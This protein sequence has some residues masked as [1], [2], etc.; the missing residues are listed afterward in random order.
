MRGRP[1]NKSLGSTDNVM[2]DHQLETYKSLISIANEGF[3][4]SA[5]INGGAAVAIL[6]YLGNVAGKNVPVPNM[7]CAMAFF[8][9]GIFLCGGA[10]VFAYVTQLTLFNE[11]HAPPPHVKHSKYLYIAITLVVLS[12]VAFGVGSLFAVAQ[13]K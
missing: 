13:F 8:V 12:L 3:K 2:N 10:M 6:A 1:L 11:L 4:F 9:S 7:Q 5:L